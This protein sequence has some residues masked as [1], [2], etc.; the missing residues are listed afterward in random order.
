MR[1]TASK[2]WTDDTNIKQERCQ[3]IYRGE[4]LKYSP[5]SYKGIGYS[6][7]IPEWSSDP[8]LIAPD[9][10]KL[11]SDRAYDWPPSESMVPPSAHNDTARYIRPRKDRLSKPPLHRQIQ[12]GGILQVC[13]S[14][15]EGRLHAI[16]QAFHA[17][18]PDCSDISESFYYLMVTSQIHQSRLFSAT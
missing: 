12:A 5:E 9:Q 3:N 14:I 17:H 6:L 18:R 10:N 13:M 16:L 11:R 1:Q 8:L 2:G 15:Q 4:R 7:L